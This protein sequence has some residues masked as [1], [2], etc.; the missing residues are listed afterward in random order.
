MNQSSS[1]DD[2]TDFEKAIEGI[3]PLAALIAAYYNALV[4]SGLSKKDALTLTIEYQKQM[5]S[6]IGRHGENR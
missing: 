1:D 4:E 3:T 5:L 2:L 6:S